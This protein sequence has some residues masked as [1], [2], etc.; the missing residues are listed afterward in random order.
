MG[1]DSVLGASKPKGFLGLPVEIRLQIYGY[2][3]TP[4]TQRFY[5]NTFGELDSVSILAEGDQQ[6]SGLELAL[7][8]DQHINSNPAKYNRIHVAILRTC[9]LILAEA[10]PVLYGENV[11]TVLLS[12]PVPAT[13]NQQLG[14]RKPSIN[15]RVRSLYAR[16]EKTGRFTSRHRVPDFLDGT[17]SVSFLAQIGERNMAV[18]KH[19][20]IW[21]FHTDHV[22]EY[23]PIMS[24]IITDSML[25]LRTAVFGLYS[26]DVDFPGESYCLTWFEALRGGRELLVGAWEDQWS[27]LWRGAWDVQ[28]LPSFY[29]DGGSPMDPGN[30]QGSGE[31]VDLE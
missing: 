3:L 10:A 4:R 12:R 31:I 26:V 29:H 17:P 18:I 6:E 27:R 30:F 2:L 16:V 15:T 22:K 24:R 21:S 20:E 13:T 7:Y 1:T 5:N 9:K 25:D 19:L 23:M 14:V 8:R 28:S 11:F